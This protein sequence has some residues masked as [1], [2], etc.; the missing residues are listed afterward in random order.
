[1][2]RVTHQRNVNGLPTEKDFIPSMTPEQTRLVI[3]HLKAQPSGS[4]TKALGLVLGLRGTAASP[5]LKQLCDQGLL[6]QTVSCKSRVYQLVESLT[7]P[8][9]VRHDQVEAVLTF[10]Q[11]RREMIPAIARACDLTPDETFAT[12]QHLVQIGQLYTVTVGAAFIYFRPPT[13]QRGPA[14]ADLTDAPGSA[15]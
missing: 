12:C 2:T 7:D 11:G 15:R 3:D 1:M 13:I 4:T 10:L 5:L 8:Q 6:R 14:P 9:Q